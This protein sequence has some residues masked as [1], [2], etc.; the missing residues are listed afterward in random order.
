MRSLSQHDRPTDE[1]R[2]GSNGG[3]N[4]SGIGAAA[5]L[6]PADEFAVLGLDPDD[7]VGDPVPGDLVADLAVLVRDAGRD[8][9]HGPDSHAGSSSAGTTRTLACRRFA[10]G[11]LSE[12]LR[13]RG[14]ANLFLD[15]R[16][17]LEMLT[18]PGSGFRELAGRIR[19]AADELA[20]LGADR[21]RLQ[22]HDR[23]MHADQHDAR[24]HRAAFGGR[25]Q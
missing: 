14:P 3:K 13:G 5:G 22:L 16:A 6:A 10:R 4:G 8:R 1:R 23:R 20:L 17:E 15:E 2:H 7:D 18:E 12:R 25:T 9:R 11:E 21:V 24:L 19:K